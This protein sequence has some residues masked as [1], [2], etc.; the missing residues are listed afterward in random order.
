[1]GCEGDGDAVVDIAPFWVV[2]PLFGPEGGL[3]HPAEGLGEIF[4]L[5]CFC[6]GVAG[7]VLRPAVFKQGREEL[8]AGCVTENF[9]QSCSS[10][11]SD[12]NGP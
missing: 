10:L 6:D 5:V 12:L 3:R 9:Y 4:E 7:G 2:V 1:V 11:L 8:F